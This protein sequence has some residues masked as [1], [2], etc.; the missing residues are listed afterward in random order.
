LAIGTA[1]KKMPGVS[2]HSDAL[3]PQAIIRDQDT[4]I[5]TS[6]AVDFSLNQAKN[7]TSFVSIFVGFGAF[8]LWLLFLLFRFFVI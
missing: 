1:V 5:N 4:F 2:T 7:S 8:A 6:A 3:L